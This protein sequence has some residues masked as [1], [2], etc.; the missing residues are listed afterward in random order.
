MLELRPINSCHYRACTYVLIVALVPRSPQD[1]RKG[2]RGVQC[3]LAGRTIA[4]SWGRRLVLT[5][6]NATLEAI[7]PSPPRVL[8]AQAAFGGFCQTE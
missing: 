4:E 5:E 1:N 7:S 2:A 6:R 8:F 3:L